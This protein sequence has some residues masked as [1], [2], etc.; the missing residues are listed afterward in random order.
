ML[1]RSISLFAMCACLAGSG[2]A[3]VIGMGT[4]L[5]VRLTHPLS[6]TTSR[7]GDPVAAIVIAPVA[8]GS[9]TT[10]IPAGTLLTGSVEEA[11]GIG[12]GIRRGRASLRL[13]FT[14]FHDSYGRRTAACLRVSRIENSREQVSSK[15]Q[16]QGIRATDAFGFRMAGI[17]RNIFIW[18]PLL[19]GVLAA[20]TFSVLRF[21]DS[22][23][24][25]PAG[26]ELTLT[27]AQPLHVDLPLSTPFATEE[28]EAD[29]EARQ[30]AQSTTLRTVSEKGRPSDLVN[31]VLI[32]QQAWIEE[33]FHA[34][35]WTAAD[36]LTKSTG[37]K[38]FHAVAESRGYPEAP[39]SAQQLDEQPT[40]LEYSKS[41]DTYSRRH[42]V[43]IYRQAALDDG[44]PVFAASSTQDLAIDYN[45]K[46]FRLEHRVD[47]NIDRERSKI[48]ND[49]NLT[50]CV[51]SWSL[52]PRPAA[53]GWITLSTG[54]RVRSD[55]ALLVV[56][57]NDCSA[58]R[59]L[60]IAPPEP[61]IA[62][63][64]SIPKRV[65]RNF[66]LTVRNDFT[67][68]NPVYQAVLGVKYVKRNLRRKKDPALAE[69]AAA[70]AQR[71][72]Y[73]GEPE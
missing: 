29:A 52:V 7:P 47:E 6:T 66:M 59:K 15:G 65:T 41:L 69:V 35:G 18:D 24:T 50:A 37:W 42:H 34:A 67:R 72:E 33:A 38:T 14:E 26:T 56:R 17:A 44:T 3:A 16:I 28:K 27:V 57:L 64:P 11:H 9:Q 1:R 20:S 63:R 53:A 70:P 12:W 71:S 13:A 46:R 62:R 5:E 21:P 25:L 43:R 39:M 32:G 49:L 4:S 2:H 60:V 61:L 19:Q 22:E 48:L 45:F 36:A 55:G 51:D 30:L 68:N 73:T 31:V 58:R 54:Q 23:I 10:A 40:A 8:D